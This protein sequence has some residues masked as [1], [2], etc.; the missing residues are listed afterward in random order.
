M[1]GM[2]ILVIALATEGKFPS[3]AA[4]LI[5]GARGLTASG[6]SVSAAVLGSGVEGLCAEAAA[7]G[8]DRVFCV[9]SSRLQNYESEAYLVALEKVAEESGAGAILFPS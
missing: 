9:D 5:G 2:D 6:G 3:V 4:E 8:A 1:M 7:F